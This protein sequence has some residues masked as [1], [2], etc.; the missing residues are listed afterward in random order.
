LKIRIHMMFAMIDVSQLEK[1][2]EGRE[3]RLDGSKG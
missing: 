3:V 2:W 1:K